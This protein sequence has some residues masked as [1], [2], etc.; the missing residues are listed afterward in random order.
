MQEIKPG[1][2][3]TGPL[4]GRQVEIPEVIKLEID[5]NPKTGVV[6]VTGPLILKP[7]CLHALAGAIDVIADWKPN[8]PSVKPKIEILKPEGQIC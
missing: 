6:N 1:A 5:Y 2:M 7:F 4:T 8:L 3:G